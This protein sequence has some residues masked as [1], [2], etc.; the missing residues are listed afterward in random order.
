MRGAT[1]SAREARQQNRRGESG[2]DKR[3]VREK[4]KNKGEPR[5]GRERAETGG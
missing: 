5:G 4:E 1:A 2:E 3:K